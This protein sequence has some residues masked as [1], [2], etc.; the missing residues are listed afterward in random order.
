[1]EVLLLGTGSADGWPNAFC[2]CGSCTWARR[3]GVH[4]LTTSALVDGMLLLDCGPHTAAQAQRAG[5]DLAGVRH[6][7]VTHAHPDHSAPM[8]LLSR[9][10]AGTPAPLHVYGPAPVLD[11]WRQW[12]GPGDPVHWHLA[13]PGG[14]H[15]ADGYR[16]R[17]LAAAHDA[18]ESVL[19]DVTDSRGHRLL[20]ATDTGPVPAETL[21]ACAA[22]DFDLVLLEET[23]GE[24]TAPVSG[25]GPDH[26]DL[27]SFG[28]E[29]QRLRD[30]GAVGDTTDVVAVHLSHRNPPG[31]GLAERLGGFGARAVPDGT[32]LVTGAPDV[33]RVLVTGG[34]RSGKSR[35]AETLVS[36]YRALTYV[37]P[38]YPAG[39]GD[40]E[41]RARV[42]EHQRRR[43]A[44]WTTL[45]T[46]CAAE[47][48]RQADQPVL[49]DCVGTWLA[50]VLDECGAW[51]Q[52]D[53][54]QAR[55]DAAVDDLV[56]AWRG[57]RVP[58][59]AVTNE[60]G[61]GVHPPTPAG[62][63][64]RDLLG[65]VNARLAADADEVLLLVAGR[66]QR[67]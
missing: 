3:E 50:R 48:L 45:E 39:D 9:A 17:V 47:A 20:Y 21:D 33:V 5:A 44:H 16:V 22:A 41:W 65:R 60:V 56:S 11:H 46:P 49:L 14:E 32:R 64:F 30:V 13:S 26:L 59:V 57:A 8:A 58:V 43:P 15:D 54:W 38:G 34:A 66:V 61:S 10:W 51:H 28:A 2:Q 31:P 67:L 35:H 55:V 18:T 52:R 19:Y 1:M 7:F 29:L 4:R 27:E 63:V 12:A 40:A 36:G 24:R 6:L 23:F 62:R 25:G 37:A 42:A 53:G